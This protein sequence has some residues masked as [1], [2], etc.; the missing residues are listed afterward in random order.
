MYFWQIATSVFNK[1]ESA[2]H[3]LFNGAEV[4]SSTSDKTI[5]LLKTFLRTNFDESVISLPTLTSRENLKLNNVIVT[6]KFIKKIITNL[7]FWKAAGPDCILVVVQ[8]NCELELSS[9]L[10]EPFNLCLKG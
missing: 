1:A 4:L 8:E 2:I 10:T 3:F 7:E 6:L 9:T 5:Y